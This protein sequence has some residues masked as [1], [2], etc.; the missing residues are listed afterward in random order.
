MT[1]TETTTLNGGPDFEVALVADLGALAP[2]R[3]EVARR[4]GV[5]GLAS[6]KVDDVVLVVCELCTNAI[7]A[8]EPSDAPILVRVRIGDAAVVVEVE[9]V[10][11]PFD[12][13]DAIALGDGRSDTEGGRGL[14]IV[15]TL[16]DDVSM[17]FHDG[18]CTVKAV[19]TAV[20][21]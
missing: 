1:L 5:Q 21:R 8:T 20:D 14:A 19:I 16:S 10:G 6:E 17:H 11:P 18:R 7:Q 13:L 15:R 4:L 2:S 9:N 3:R 12:A